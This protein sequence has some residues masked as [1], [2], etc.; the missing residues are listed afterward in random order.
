MMAG[1]PSKYK[2]EY[3]EQARELPFSEPI[4]VRLVSR[5]KVE[6]LLVDAMGR[7]YAPELRRRDE[8]VKK[9]LAKR[10]AERHAS[11]AELARELEAVDA[12][13]NSEPSA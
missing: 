7:A 13:P 10:P 6:A 1:R 11:A 12:A 3:A 8:V 2:P 5:G 4:Q 9:A